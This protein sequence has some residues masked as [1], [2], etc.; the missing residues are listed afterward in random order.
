MPSEFLWLDL[1]PYHSYKDSKVLLVQK[2]FSIEKI[3]HVLMAITMMNGALLTIQWWRV[4]NYGATVRS[5]LRFL[6][7]FSAIKAKAGHCFSTAMHILEYPVDLKV[8]GHFECAFPIHVLSAVVGKR[9]TQRRSAQEDGCI[10]FRTE[11]V[12]KWAAN[13]MHHTIDEEW[14]LPW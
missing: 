6:R 11:G 14:K 10:L 5:H 3:V 1:R 2:T 13:G 4:P 12:L 8:F 9:G 7:S